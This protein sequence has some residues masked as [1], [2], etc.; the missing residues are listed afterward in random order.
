VNPSSTTSR[1]KTPVVA[2]GL[3][4]GQEAGWAETGIVVD[5]LI[6]TMGDYLSKTQKL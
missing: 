2:A 4:G 6:V 5:E 3:L 1:E